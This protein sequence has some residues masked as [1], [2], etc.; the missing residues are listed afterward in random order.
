[1]AMVVR[2]LKLLLRLELDWFVLVLARHRTDK[3]I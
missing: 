2:Q 1:M 3:C